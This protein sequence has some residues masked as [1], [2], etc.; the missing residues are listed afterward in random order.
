MNRIGARASIGQGSRHQR[1]V[2]LAV[3]L[4]LLLV[5]ALLGIASLSGTLLEERMSTAQYDRSL[6]FQAAE[7]ALREAE[8]LAR[9]KPAV[10]ASGCAAGIC[11]RP[12]PTQADQQ[13]RWKNTDFWTDG[14]GNWAEAAVEV[15]GLTSSPRYIIELMDDAVPDPSNCTTGGDVSLEAN[16]TILSSRYRI[17]VRAQEEGRAAVMLQSTYSV[18]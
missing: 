1:G 11:A 12:D 8:E 3:V 6:A 15:G 17:T 14:S 7:A 13:Q 9:S 5:M 16:C 18:P 10:P 2:V 4:I